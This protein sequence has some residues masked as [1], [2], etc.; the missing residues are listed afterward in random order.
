MHCVRCVVPCI[1]GVM[2]HVWCT[3]ACACLVLCVGVLV[4]VHMMYVSMLCECVCLCVH[5][6]VC[7][8]CMHVHVL[9]C[10]YANVRAPCA[11]CMCALYM[12]VHVCAGCAYV[13]DCVSCVHL[14]RACVHVCSV[15]VCV[16]RVHAHVWCVHVC[17]TCVT[18]PYPMPVTETPRVK[19]YPRA[20]RAPAHAM[21]RAAVRKAQARGGGG[22]CG[23]ESQA[24]SGDPPRPAQLLPRGCL[25]DNSVRPEPGPP[26]GA[27]GPGEATG[28][29]GTCR[30][31]PGR[32][33]PG[34]WAT[35]GGSEEPAS[36]PPGGSVAPKQGPPALPCSTGC[37]AQVTRG[38]EGPEGHTGSPGYSLIPSPDPEGVGQRPGHGAARERRERHS[39]AAMS[40]RV[41]SPSAGT[42][43][44]AGSQEAGRPHRMRTQRHSGLAASPSGVRALRSGRG[45]GPS[46]LAGVG[47]CPAVP[48]LPGTRLSAWSTVALSQHSR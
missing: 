31:R 40:W 43:R 6:C 15:L 48:S 18:P 29:P 27:A 33:D 3:F 26:G 22:R 20:S 4:C 30:T 13:C 23:Q 39:R 2:L 1:Y 14:L 21:G 28:V 46:V 5:T 12:C 17:V 37:S 36:G 32:D 42:C 38:A 10:M 11:A 47:L 16:L 41:P 8:A 7:C 34:G 19:P 25:L 9:V 45:T 44:R 35:L 24:F